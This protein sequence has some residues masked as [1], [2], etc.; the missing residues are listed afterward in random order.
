MKSLRFTFA[1][2]ALGLVGILPALAQKK[3]VSPRDLV[4]AE[5]GGGKITLSYGRP[6]TKDPKTGEVRKIWGGL[7]PYGKVWRTGANEATVLTTEKPLVFGSTTI[8]AGSY[9]LWTIPAADGSAKLVFNKQ[10][11]QWGTRHDAAQDLATVDLKK[12]ALES[13]VDQ[14]TM[15]IDSTGSS[16]GAIKLMWEATSYSAPF[17]VGK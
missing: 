17:S 8:P 11:G 9:S 5:I 12:D 6:F 4:T 3:Q 15:A 10:T 2:F 7:V 13:P 1:L 16:G 14:F